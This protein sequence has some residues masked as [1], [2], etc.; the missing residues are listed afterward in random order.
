MKVGGTLVCVSGAILMGLFRGPALIGYSESD[1]STENEIIAR[2]QPEPAGW[3]MYSFMEYGIRQ[4]HVGVLCLI[5]NCVCM[6]AYLAIQVL[7]LH[8]FFFLVID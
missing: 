4:W 7:D 1:S 3:L 2:G 6:A 8:F 5:G